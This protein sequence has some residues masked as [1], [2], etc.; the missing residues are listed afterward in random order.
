MQARDEL[1]RL[2]GKRTIMSAVTI[3]PELIASVLSSRGENRKPRAMSDEVVRQIRALDAAGLKNG[4]IAKLLGLPPQYVSHVRRGRAY[5]DVVGFSDIAQRVID[6]VNAEAYAAESEAPVVETDDEG[7][8]VEGADAP[9]DAEN[10]QAVADMDAGDESAGALDALAAPVM[11]DAPMVEE[12]LV[13]TEEALVA[14]SGIAAKA[15]RSRRGR[16]A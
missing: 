6:E 9:T 10:E 3:T 5:R 16:T 1:H 2:K 14:E 13:L 12:M 4:E 7:Y 8:L 15:P 11:E